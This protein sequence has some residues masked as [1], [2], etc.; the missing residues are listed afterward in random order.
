MGFVRRFAHRIG[1]SLVHP[2]R[3]LSWSDDEPGRA[4]GDIALFFSLY[5]AAVFPD[6]LARAAVFLFA[7][8]FSGTTYELMNV[9]S[10]GLQGALF[11]LIVSGAVL[12]VTGHKHAS[13]GT[14]FD[15]AC[16]VLVPLVLVSLCGNLYATVFGEGK[17]VRLWANGIGY[18]VAGVWLLIAVMHGRKPSG[19]DEN[20][21]RSALWLGASVVS[22]ALVIG[23]IN[24]THVVN[25]W[26][27]I[28]PMTR[29]SSA[30]DVALTPIDE[31]GRLATPTSVSAYRG[32]VLVLDFWAT[33][34]GPCRRSMPAVFEF[35]KEWS[36]KGVTLLS[37][38][39]ESADGA[40]RARDFANRR[41]PGIPLFSDFDH[42]ASDAYGASNIPYLV[43]V[44]KE[45]VVRWT[46]RGFS[47]E[48]ALLRE[49]AEAVEPLL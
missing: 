22:L 31:V 17:A 18:G 42:A 32:Q 37:I 38:N 14:Q 45:G 26:D 2:R 39:T 41:I 10:R 36:P 46:H 21:S 49:L 25:E 47:T 16:V 6:K 40:A 12:A 43:V 20:E 19:A 29:G 34:C 27:N 35:A 28:R 3:A 8:D 30:P 9:V 7:G 13:V 33:W 15:R 5:L 24:V 23:A 11:A 1:L 44:D 48:E 4:A